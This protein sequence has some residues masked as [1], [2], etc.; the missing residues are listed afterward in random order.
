[1]REQI[2]AARQLGARGYLLWN[3]LGVYTPGA[4]T[5]RGS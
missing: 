1:V 4:L 3:P 2:D 5:P